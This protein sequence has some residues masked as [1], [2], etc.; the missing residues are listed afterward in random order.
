MLPESAPLS[1]G[2]VFPVQYQITYLFRRLERPNTAYRPIDVELGVVG[3]VRV[4]PDPDS[5]CT[6]PVPPCSP[7]SEVAP[8]LAVELMV[9]CVLILAAV[10]EYTQTERLIL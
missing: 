3:G 2:D 8:V 1:L 7:P 5:E 10:R 6:Q 4:Y 9:I